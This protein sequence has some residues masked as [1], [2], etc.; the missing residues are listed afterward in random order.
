VRDH[1]GGDES[2]YFPRPSQIDHLS[3][4]GVIMILTALVFDFLFVFTK[5]KERRENTKQGNV[6]KFVGL[7]F[8]E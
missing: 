1:D 7:Q 5:S 8:D 4:A 6:G 3:S 2:G